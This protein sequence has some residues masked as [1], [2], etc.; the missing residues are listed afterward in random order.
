[1]RQRVLLLAGQLRRRTLRVVRVEYRVVPVPAVADRRRQDLPVPHRLEQ[2]LGAVG[3]D[4]G[5]RADEGRSALDDTLQVPQQQRD[6]VG[7]HPGP[8]VAGGVDAGRALE[9][10]DRDARVVGER[11]QPGVRHG[12]ARLDQR[13]RRVGVAVLD[14]LRPV[15]A[16]ELDPLAERLA[17]DPA[18]LDDLALVVRRQDDGAPGHASPSASRWMAASD[19]LPASPRS[20][21]VS[22]S[23]RS[24]GACSAVP[25]TSMNF[26]EPVV[27]MFMSVS[28]AESSVYARSSIGS[29]PTMPTEIACTLSVSGVAFFAMK[30]LSRPHS[31]ASTMATYA[32]VIDAVRV[33]PSAC[34]TSQSSTRVFSPRPFMSTTARSDRPIRREISCVRPPTLPLIDSRCMRSFVERGS[35]EYSAVTQ[36]EPLPAIQRGTPFVKDAVQSTF[37][38]PNEMSALPSAC[39]LHPRSMLTG[40]WSVA[41]RPSMRVLMGSF[42]CGAA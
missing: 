33:P 23:A 27:T 6:V 15:V 11:R 38:L 22:S 12:R 29:P 2:V 41:L 13:V 9:G 30:P 5:R 19:R 20:S 10:V 36:P 32:P 7:V 25:C 40:R 4:E 28:A 21:S 26:P 35:I 37:V 18:E 3:G 14:R 16:D 39:V 8:R 24:N 1:M 34:S 31:I 17:E 42:R